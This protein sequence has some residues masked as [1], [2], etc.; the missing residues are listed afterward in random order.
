MARNSETPFDILEYWKSQFFS[1]PVMSRI[2]KDVLVVP[3]T[4]VAA[5]SSFSMGGRD[6]M[7]DDV[8]HDSLPRED[9]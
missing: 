5:E 3:I 4:S 6:M 2:V 7:P 8:D 9:A 1:F